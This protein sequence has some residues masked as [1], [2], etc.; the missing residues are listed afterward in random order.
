MSGISTAPNVSANDAMKLKRAMS[1][2]QTGAWIDE[3]IILATAEALI[4]IVR[5]HTAVDAG[6]HSSPQVY[7]SKQFSNNQPLSVAFYLPGHYRTVLRLDT[8]SHQQE[9]AQKRRMQIRLISL[10][11]HSR[12]G[13]LGKSSKSQ[14]I[15][16]GLLF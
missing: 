10:V 12:L 5:V 16:I 4:R 7:T 11:M 13:T 14:Q 8:V 2:L 1:I 9:N 3:D 6:S 15:N